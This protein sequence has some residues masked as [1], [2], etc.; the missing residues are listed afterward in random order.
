M[1][2]R[3]ILMATLVCG[4]IVVARD[5]RAQQP[6]DSEPG[7]EGGRIGLT[8]AYPA[9]GVS[10]GLIGLIWQASDR[11]ALRP[12]VSI[13]ARIAGDSTNSGAND[14]W[15]LGA[16]LTVLCYVGRREGVAAYVGPRL[17]YSWAWS[18]GG[19]T[20]TRNAG[21]GVGVNGGLQYSLTKK[22]VLFGEVGLGYLFTTYAYNGATYGQ[23]NTSHSISSRSAL[24]LN[25]YF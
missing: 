7:R 22:I 19:G 13:S 16:T 2:R 4:L 20:D 18:G 14:S 12:E 8:L 9:S 17:S 21:Y 1:T 11:L 10:S 3:W 5:A 6:P 15:S 25:L 23:R 24:G